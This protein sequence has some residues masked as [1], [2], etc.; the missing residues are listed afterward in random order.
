LKSSDWWIRSEGATGR[1]G[2]AKKGGVST[3]R[4]DYEWS[5]SLAKL[6]VRYVQI[7]RDECMRLKSL[8]AHKDKQKKDP[9]VPFKIYLKEDIHKLLG[10]K[11]DE[12]V[13]K[14]KLLLIEKLVVIG[15][16]EL[17]GTFVLCTYSLG[18][19]VAFDVLVHARVYR[20]DVCR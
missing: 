1:Y 10:A 18:L 20:S 7:K 3:L 17:R 11:N 9:R 12:I 6:I 14:P 5:K 15:A 4:R 19:C 8:Q 13:S 2:R 16:M